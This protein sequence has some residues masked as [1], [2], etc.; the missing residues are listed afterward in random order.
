MIDLTDYKIYLRREERSVNTIEKYIRDLK[1]FFS[2]LGNRELCKEV[3]VNWKGHLSKT[4]APA[5]VNSM[6]ASVNS[7][8][9]WSDLPQMKVRPLKIQ[10]E[11][12]TKP[13]KELTRTEYNRLIQAAEKKRNE[14][15]ALL[16]Q[17]IC[18]TGIRVSELK[19]ITAD[20][21]RTGRAAVEC[22]G[23]ARTVFLPKELRRM[24]ERYRR[25]RGILSGSIFCTASGKPLDRSN[26]WRD[27]KS[28]CESADVEPE[29]VFPHN[30]RHLF[31]RT[32]Y[33]LEKDLS[34]LADL[35]GHSSVNTT[36]IYTK[37][38]GTEHEKLINRLDLIVANKQTT[39]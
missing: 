30:L 25:E 11:F 39:T 8:L 15:L 4:Y 12:Y 13:E 28:L 20:A 6:L 7:F 35:L 37:E 26:I 1:A 18:A 38:S 16:L 32:C 19:F 29:K 24:L 27:M 34:R 33:Q 10:R 31:A 36:R 5:S 3:V 22:K 17:T 14:R 2:F 9:A 23:K 21:V